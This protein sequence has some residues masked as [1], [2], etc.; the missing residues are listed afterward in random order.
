MMVD[1]ES[2]RQL[3]NLYASF[4]EIFRQKAELLRQH[5]AVA[6]ELLDRLGSLHYQDLNRLELRR[7]SSTTLTS[8]LDQPLTELQ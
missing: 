7:E 4:P 3:E 6:R 2:Y 5:P 8:I 1:E